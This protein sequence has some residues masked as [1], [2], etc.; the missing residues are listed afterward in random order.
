MIPS[1]THVPRRLAADDG[2]ERRVSNRPESLIRVEPTRSLP[3]GTWV[4]TPT[5]CSAGP[6][7]LSRAGS[8]AAGRARGYE[9]RTA[10]ERAPPAAL[11]CSRAQRAGGG[12][13]VRRVAAP[14]RSNMGRTR[15]GMGRARTAAQ[16]ARAGPGRLGPARAA[17]I[18]VRPRARWRSR[19]RDHGHVPAHAVARG[20]AP[21]AA[22]GGAVRKRT[23]VADEGRGWPG[24]GQLG[25]SERAALSALRAGPSPHRPPDG[26]RRTHCA[27]TQRG[28]RR[29]EGRGGEPVR[30]PPPRA[31]RAADR[32]AAPRN[33]G[34]AKAR[35]EPCSNQRLLHTPNHISYTVTWH[36]RRAGISRLWDCLVGLRVGSDLLIVFEVIRRP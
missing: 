21:W 3:D 10:E 2:P 16:P 30:G 34:R 14:V 36:L 19:P 20:L 17:R 18:A 31:R 9:T 28:P 26:S 8:P 5:P 1:L 13:R 25:D 7:R 35:R 11:S 33:E 29:P 32:P 23:G 6:A 24:P 27:R 12:P 22:G 15:V 4:C